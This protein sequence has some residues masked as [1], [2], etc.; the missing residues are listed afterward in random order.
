MSSYTDD[1]EVLRLSDAVRAIHEDLHN[2]P[3][4]APGATV[5]GNEFQVLRRWNS[6]TP[7]L[8]FSYGG[9]YLLRWRGKGIVIDPGVTFLDVF[10]HAHPVEGMRAHRMDD[11]D[12]VLVTHD[13]ADHCEDVGMLLVFLRNYNKRFKGKER[14]IDFVQSLGAHFRSVILLNNAE[15]REWVR[16]IDIPPPRKGT[17]C[18]RA[19]LNLK[20]YHLELTELCTHHTEV[21]GDRSALGFRMELES[22]T[23]QKIVFCDTGDTKYDASLAAEYRGDLVLLH[24]GTME[25]VRTE[26][27]GHGEHL[28]F[29]GVL[30]ILE[31]LKI[32]QPK[33]V[34]LG[35]W[36]EEFRGP[37]YRRRFTET[38]RR[39]A[40]Y[41]GP[42]LPADLGMRIRLE[43]CH[44]MC[45]NGA[46]EQWTPAADVRVRDYGQWIEYHA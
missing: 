17:T 41:S 5:D 2:L 46:G 16:A 22:D 1:A 33:L 20:A 9:G 13:H 6:H 32:K 8:Q 23:G 10:Q 29:V 39:V 21:L 37:G 36:G 19:P 18:S 25:D 24:V 34:L 35:E 30:R 3:F 40:G 11:I 26:P 42:V 38:V 15:T 44:V 27:D 7:M 14:H 31:S 28:C 12:M 43:D 4:F 45:R